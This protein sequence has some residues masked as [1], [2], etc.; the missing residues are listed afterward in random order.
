M[1]GVGAVSEAVGGCD[2]AADVGCEW[3]QDQSGMFERTWK[4]V[5]LVRAGIEF[6][7]F[8]RYGGCHDRLVWLHGLAQQL[9]SFGG[10]KTCGEEAA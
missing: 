10:V 2:C 9:I 7:L 1:E 6:A 4:W 3:F 8:G 5:L